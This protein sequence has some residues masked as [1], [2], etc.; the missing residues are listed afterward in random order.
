MSGFFPC[1]D[2]QS[3]HEGGIA[4][5]KRKTF[6]PAL[7]LAIFAASLTLTLTSAFAQQERVL[8]SFY[9]NGRD[10]FI[11]GSS[12]VIDAAGNLYGT[13]PDAGYFGVGLV[14]ELTP[15]PGGGWT[16]KPLH[17]FSG[18]EA[19]GSSPNAALIFD[20]AGNLYGTTSFGGEDGV[21][22]VF[23]L[24]PTTSGTW[25]ETV[26]Y[27]F[28]AGTSGDGQNPGSVLLLHASGNNAAIL[29]GTT[30]QGGTNNLGTAFELSPSAD[31][32]YTET[33][34]HSFGS[35]T[36]GKSPKAGLIVD[37][38]GNLYGTTTAGGIYNTGTVFELTPTG[39]ETIL[40]SFKPNGR[41]GAEPVGGLV[42]DQ[43]GNLYGTTD[44]GGSFKY[45][46]VFEV[47]PASK[48]EKILHNFSGLPQT[49]RIQIL[50]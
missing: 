22:T 49:D 42:M 14:F 18:R 44:A 32:G 24:S 47:E 34:L 30:L 28:G 15:K 13:T 16:S 2:Q 11:P 10:G 45:G 19:D 12:L 17:A 26:L 5:A 3:P 9:S 48:S 8:H 39:E 25:S 43:A 20:T 35:G 41:D 7:V 31:G 1:G 33:V 29:Y 46:T 36:D 50:N 6:G 4:H 21:G 27:S 40:H 37:P 38:A 23:E